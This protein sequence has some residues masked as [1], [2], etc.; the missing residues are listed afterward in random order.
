MHRRFMS[1]LQM[2]TQEVI[3]II[4][5]ALHHVCVRGG[6]VLPLLV[7]HFGTNILLFARVA[8]GL[9][10]MTYGYSMGCCE[11]V[12]SSMVRKQISK[13]HGFDL[14]ATVETEAASSH[15]FCLFAAC[16]S[17]SFLCPCSRTVCCHGVDIQVIHL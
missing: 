7:T 14:L 3:V 5:I 2:R 10:P 15:T 1:E 12:M 8:W 4:H 9:A 6:A 11:D 16:A 17:M 13:P